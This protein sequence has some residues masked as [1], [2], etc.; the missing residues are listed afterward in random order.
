MTGEASIGRVEALLARFPRV[1]LGRFPTPLDPLPH[2]GRLIGHERLYIKRDDLTELALGGNK[3]RNLEFLIG[4]A[5]AQGA[6]VILAAGGLQSNY[7]RLAAAAAAK[8]GLDCILVHNAERPERLEGNQLLIHLLGTERRFI[9]TVD[10]AKRGRHVAD[11]AG[12]LRSRGRKP[13]IVG[14]SPVSTLGY[15]GAA[16]ELYRQS[17]ELGVG[18]RHVVIVGAMAGTATGFLY[19][20]ALLGMPFTVHVISVEYPE[21]ELRRLINEAWDGVTA[22]TGERHSVSADEAGTLYDA[23]LGDGYA[24]PTPQSLQVV[25]DLAR[26]E[27]VFIETVYNSKT[28]WGLVDLVERGVIPRNAPTCFITTGGIPALF[29]QA[30]ILT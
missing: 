29:A 7:C 17:Q 12:E 18:L 19:G 27:A 16:F 15:V 22:L 24:R 3:V 2:F 26:T 1:S 25:R 28:L 9:G 5:L 13:Y 8:V 21:P 4:D 20:N 10:E 6:D 11:L 23:Y 30:D 14:Y